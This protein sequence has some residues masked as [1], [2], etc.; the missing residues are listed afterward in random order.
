MKKDFL[1][2]ILYKK[3]IKWFPCYFIDF[4]FFSCENNNIFFKGNFLTKLDRRLNWIN[5]KFRRPNQTKVK[6]RVLKCVSANLEGGIC[7]LAYFFQ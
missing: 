2:K 6:F 7:I 1:K 3:S 4:F 5:L